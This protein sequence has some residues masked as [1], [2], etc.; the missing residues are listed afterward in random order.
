MVYEIQEYTICDGWV[1]TWTTWSKPDASDEHPETF[2]SQKKAQE[3][4]NDFFAEV[5]ESVENGNMEGSYDPDNFRI[6]RIK[7]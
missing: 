2:T 6:K 3:A 7:A 4:L 5:N 1:N